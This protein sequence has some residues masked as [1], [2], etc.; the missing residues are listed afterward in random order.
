MGFAT[1]PELI[2][3]YQLLVMESILVIFIFGSFAGWLLERVHYAL[4]SQWSRYGLLSGPYL[5]IYGLGAVAL[6]FIWQMDVPL[7]WKVV[8]ISLAPTLLEL[9]AGISLLKIFG[10]RL[11]DYFDCRFHLNGV[12]CL[13]YSLLWAGLTLSFSFLFFP[14]FQEISWNISV[15]RGFLAI[16]FFF[17]GIDLFYAARN[18]L[19]IRQYRRKQK[20]CE[21]DYRHVKSNLLPP[22]KSFLF[23][24]VRF[25][26]LRTFHGN[27]LQP[28]CRKRI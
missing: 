23:E 10:V 12:I 26:D 20:N 7:L 4:R 22:Q 8:L 25:F 3:S 17:F 14:L 9:I 18:L 11:W 2:R 21:I 28:F 27:V 6:F 1:Y 15:L 24:K 16:F 5:P 13:Q 19:Y